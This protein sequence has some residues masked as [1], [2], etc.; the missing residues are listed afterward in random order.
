MAGRYIAAAVAGRPALLGLHNGY[1]PL[2]DHLA[3]IEA[4]PWDGWQ[5]ELLERMNA[6]A[7]DAP[8][9]DVSATLLEAHLLAL[10]HQAHHPGHDYDRMLV[11]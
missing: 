4:A 8:T 7:G 5:G 3:G 11:L 9:D 6:R 2:L 10:W 1:N